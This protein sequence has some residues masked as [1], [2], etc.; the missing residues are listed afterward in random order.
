MPALTLD[1]T[2]DVYTV[3]DHINGGDLI[4]F[5]SMV[6]IVEATGPA[7]DNVRVTVRGKCKNEDSNGNNYQVC[8]PQSNHNAANDWLAARIVLYSQYDTEVARFVTNTHFPQL[9]CSKPRQFDFQ[10]TTHT[11]SNNIQE[12]ENGRAVIER[13]SA[14]LNRCGAPVR[15]VDS[16]GPPNIGLRD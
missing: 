8:T 16:S 4:A 11:L 1:I 2:P 5:R 10:L 6:A 9:Y 12:F 3:G 13:A 14:W 7:L 15:R